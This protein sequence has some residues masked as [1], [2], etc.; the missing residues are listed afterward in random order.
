MV[1]HSLQASCHHLKNNYRQNLPFN[2]YERM[3]YLRLLDYTLCVTTIE[4][5]SYYL[6]LIAAM[7]LLY[8]DFFDISIWTGEGLLGLRVWALYGKD[9]R[10]T[11]VLLAIFIGLTTTSLISLNSF[12]KSMKCTSSQSRLFSY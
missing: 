6:M 10:L 4:H 5:T 7:V 3:Y 2:Y 9:K 12:A 11:V 8:A 1:R